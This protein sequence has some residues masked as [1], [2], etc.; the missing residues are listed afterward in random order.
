MRANLVLQKF[1]ISRITDDKVVV[2]IG[3]RNT[4]KSFLIRDLLYHHRDIPVG[5]VISGTEMANG[6]FA[7]MVPELFIHHDFSPDVVDS[8]MKRQLMMRRR[9]DAAKAAATTLPDI[10]AF[11]ILDDLMYDAKAWIKDRN[12]RSMFF[13]GRH[14]KLFFMLSMQY[15]LGIPPELRANIDYVFI[16]REQ[17][18]ANRKRLYDNFAGMFGSF[19][20]FCQV[21]D[22]CTENY[23]CLVIDNTVKSNKLQEQVFWYK[24]EPHED[25]KVGSRQFWDPA[26]NAEVR[27]QR[28]AAEMAALEGTGVP[29]GAKKRGAA[30]INVR[31][32]PHGHRG[33]GGSSWSDDDGGSD[34]DDDGLR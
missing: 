7:Q 21:M 3:K 24:A 1:D 27:R 29:A 33:G 23:E 31:K 30:N 15:P 12:I 32:V 22:Q 18:M 13:N 10:R 8:V 5:T 34:S 19:D 20:A 28:E 26:R 14:Y 16:L 11:V 2:F 6:F 25:F 9:Y 4:G 17:Y